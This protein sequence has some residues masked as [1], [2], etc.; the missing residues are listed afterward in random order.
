VNPIRSLTG[1]RQFLVAFISSA[2]TLAFGRAA[3]AFDLIF[4]T[5]QAKAS[6]KPAIGERKSIRGIVVYYSAT[7]N[8]A[9]VAEALWRGMR[10]VIPCDLAPIG[11]AIVKKVEPAD[12]AKYDVIA[13]GAPNW[14]KRVPGNVLVFTHDMPRMDGK[15]CIIFGTHG[16][17]PYAQF[18]I[19]SKNILKKGMEIIGWSDWYGADFLTPHSSVPDG[20]WG[21]PDSIDL[22]EAEAFGRKMAENSIRI[23]AGERDLL[24]ESLPTPELGA[25]SLWAP[26]EEGLQGKITFPGT[27]ANSVPNFDFT[28]CVYPRCNRCIENC[29]VNA[30]DFSVIAPFNSITIE[31][32]V[33]TKTDS[34]IVLK[35]ACAQC[36]GICEKVC[37]YG[38]ISYIGATGVRVFQDIDMTKCT[39]PKCTAC[40]D[41]C[42]QNAIDVTQNPAVVHNWCENECLCFGVCPE[43]AIGFTPSSMFTDEKVFLDARARG[44]RILAPGGL[45]V[46][47]ERRE[48]MAEGTSEGVARPEGR[49]YG[50]RFRDLVPKEGVNKP[51]VIDS[52][53]Y[54]RIPMYEKLWVYHFDDEA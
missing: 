47:G 15:H 37:T 31:T 16:G 41:W 4:K 18:W 11:P 27:S 20:E 42:P 23:H 19:M 38:A 39:Y 50:P 34:P 7:G 24:P 40:M 53:V 51:R 30:I 13:I 14:Y 35:E 25:N 5:N 17:Q 3:R 2:L 43:N 48:P 32:V 33:K 28:K 29:T 22:T 10:S 8:T 12:M 46:L 36:G 21:H 1:R 54:P 45:G 49:G 26:N 6:V 44:Q 52:T 9:Q